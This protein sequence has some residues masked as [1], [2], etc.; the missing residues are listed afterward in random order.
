MIEASKENGE[1]IE[2]HR[3][4]QKHKVRINEL[5]SEK[6]FK[7]LEIQKRNKRIADL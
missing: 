2:T 7:D 3:A 4:I 6:N 5:E 1:S